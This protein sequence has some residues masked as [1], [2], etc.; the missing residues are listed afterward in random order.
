MKTYRGSFESIRLGFVPDPPLPKQEWSDRNANYPT[1]LSELHVYLDDEDA[2]KE[3]PSGYL[4]WILGALLRNLSILMQGGMVTVEWYSDPWR[5]DLSG[6]PNHDRVWITLHFPEHWVAMEDVDVPLS[7]FAQRL[8]E[9]AHQ[10]RD[11]LDSTFHE[12]MVDPKKGRDQVRF[13]EY[14]QQAEQAY[15]DYKRP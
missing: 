5:F 12:E 2:A 8:I 3:I 6:E 7:Q 4:Q 1:R 9:L 13:D 15:R 11:Y 14:L 10:W